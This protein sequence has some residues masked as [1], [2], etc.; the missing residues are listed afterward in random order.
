[1]AKVE[2]GNT[3]A[4]NRKPKKYN[5]KSEGKA[6]IRQKSTTGNQSIILER[7]R[8]RCVHAHMR[9]RSTE[10]DGEYTKAGRPLWEMGMRARGNL[11]NLIVVVGD[12]FVCGRR[13]RR[14]EIRS[15]GESGRLRGRGN[16]WGK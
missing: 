3:K 6:E 12:E 16:R 11:V 5:K 8:K 1:M 14:R 13:W 10:I 2:D 15:I 9:R 4:K 7:E